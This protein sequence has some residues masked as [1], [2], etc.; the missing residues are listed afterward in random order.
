MGATGST[1]PAY[2]YL[3]SSMARWRGDFD[4]DGLLD[5]LMAGTSPTT[6]TN[7]YLTRVYRNNGNGTFTD[8]HANLLGVA[9]GAAVWGDFDN[10][11]NLDILLTG[12]TNDLSATNPITRI[13]H[14]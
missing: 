7:I 13:Y 11:G 1:T 4:N 2:G 5:I 12:S 6:G 9:N 3:E 8:V 10:D 14:N